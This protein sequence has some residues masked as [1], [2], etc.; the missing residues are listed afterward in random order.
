MLIC[1]GY[2]SKFTGMDRSLVIPTYG[3]LIRTFGEGKLTWP[4]MSATCHFW[5]WIM[6]MG[7]GYR[8]PVGPGRGS[9]LTFWA[10]A[11]YMDLQYVESLIFTKKYYP[12]FERPPKWLDPMLNRGFWKE[13]EYWGEVFNFVRLLPGD[14]LT[15]WWLKWLQKEY[16]RIC[17]HLFA[18][19]YI[20]IYVYWWIPSSKLT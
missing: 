16:Q 1:Y 12:F 6:A 5:A 20:Y 4:G 18:N 10:V 11:I 14:S 15:V 17:L 7:R 13:F 9:G 8:S 3:G 2:G 19:I